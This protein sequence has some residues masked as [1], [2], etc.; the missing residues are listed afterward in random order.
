MGTEGIG[1][2]SIVGNDRGYHAINSSNRDLEAAIL[3][4]WM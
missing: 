2:N 3:G 1:K 4:V